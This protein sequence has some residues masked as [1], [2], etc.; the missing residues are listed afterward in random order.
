MPPTG[1]RPAPLRS[2]FRLLL[3]LGLAARLAA[4]PVTFVF[5]SDVHFGLNRGSFRGEANVESRTVNAA[6]LAKINGLPGVAFPADGGLRAGQPVGPVDFMIITGDLTNRQQLYPIHIQSA[7]ASW[8]QFEACYVAGL[9]LRDPAGRPA[10]LLLVPGNHDVSNALGYPAKMVPAT[11][12]TA[13][14]QIYNRMLS[15]ATPRTK[16]TYDPAADR[17]QYT[18]DFGGVHCVF[19]TIWPDTAAR[20]WME[21]DLQ[22]VPATTPVFLF[23]HDPPEADARHF[24]NPNGDHGINA[25]DRFENLLADTYA[26]G[27]SSDGDTVIEQRALATFL[28][29]HRNIVAFFHGHANW[30]EFYTW[31]GPDGDLALPVFRADSPMKGKFSGKNEAKLSFQVVTY[32]TATHRLTARECLWNAPGGTA[33]AAAPVAW[34]ESKT[35]T[36]AVP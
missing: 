14:A 28:K 15:P 18:R 10:P 19:L 27:T 32:D 17:I 9:A 13:L 8:A 24:T 20:A 25:H 5:A 2:A 30:N 6:M 21:H 16:D 22:A 31:K 7:A 33:A 23:C 36:L 3:L 26:D 34:G 1:R 35:I 11:D 29:V 12:A 4:V